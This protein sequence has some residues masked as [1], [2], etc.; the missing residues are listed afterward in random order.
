MERNYLVVA[1]D[2]QAREAMA[3]ALR[4]QG[5]TVT[6][7]ETAAQTKRVVRSV[8]INCVLLESH[9]SDMP[10][11]ELRATIKGIRPQCRVVVLTSFKLVR[12]TPEVLRYGGDHYLVDRDQIFELL[13]TQFDD[14]ENFDSLPLDAT[15]LID[16]G[17]WICK[18]DRPIKLY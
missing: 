4:K 14:D 13:R 8:S 5:I 1:A 17:I 15:G 11:E 12:N 18:K 16:D 6:L 7:A 3:G 10:V 9:I 2:S